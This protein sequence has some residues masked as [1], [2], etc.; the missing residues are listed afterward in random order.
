MQEGSVAL[1]S[2]VL[3]HPLKTPSEADVSAVAANDSRNRGNVLRRRSAASKQYKVRM[4]T[5][6]RKHEI[7]KL[8]HCE[9]E[10]I[11]RKHD[12][13]QQ[14]HV[15][16]NMME[17]YEYARPSFDHVGRLIIGEENIPTYDAESVILFDGTHTVLG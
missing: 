8:S 12:R 11:P 2:S 7:A 17:Y 15:V 5:M 13:V 4:E 16:Q 10:T 1:P 9:Y 3:V 14:D 6:N